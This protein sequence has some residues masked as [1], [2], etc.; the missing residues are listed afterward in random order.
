MTLLPGYHL[1]VAPKFHIDADWITR[2][3]VGAGVEEVGGKFFPRGTWRAP[4]EAEL[5]VL[6]MGPATPA[7]KAGS[8]PL[9]G[10]NPAPVLTPREGEPHTPPQ[11]GTL[12]RDPLLLTDAVCLFQIPEHLRGA[13]W[14]LLDASAEAGG[15]LQGFDEFAAQVSA[16]LAYKQLGATG[17]IQMEAIVTAAGA[18]SIRRDPDTGEPSGL[19]ST[20]APWSAWPQKGASD[21]RLYAVVNLGDEPTGVVLINLPPVSMAAELIRCAPDEPVPATA[22][23]LVERFLRVCPNY[24]P[25]RVRL[26][27]GEGCRFPAT[28]LILDGDPTRKAEPDV[29]LLISTGEA[30]G[31]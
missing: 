20:I 8:L 17:S 6:V 29:L 15:P 23:A 24:P 13:W 7:P 10:Q 2:L 5:G 11:A 28:G 19:G 3:G 16:F 12:P 1:S 14:A 30:P 31:G 25:V 21:P 18:R 22:G 9:L 27:P 4:T 26:G